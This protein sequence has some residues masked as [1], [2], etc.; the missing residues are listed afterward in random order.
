MFGL[1]IR[2]SGCPNKQI[3]GAASQCIPLRL[4][5]MHCEAMYALAEKK[6]HAEGGDW[7]RKQDTAANSAVY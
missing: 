7:L 6:L 5:G 2:I 1:S 4:K 3:Y